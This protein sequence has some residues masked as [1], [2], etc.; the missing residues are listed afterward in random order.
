MDEQARQSFHQ[1]LRANPTTGGAGSHEDVVRHCSEALERDP[2]YWNAYLLLGSALIR[3]G[4]LDQAA[5]VYRDALTRHR[6]GEDDERVLASL[7]LE[8][9]SCLVASGEPAESIEILDAYALFSATIE[10]AT[11]RAESLIALGRTQDARRIIA[12]HELAGEGDVVGLLLVKAR[13]LLV[14]GG[15]GRAREV[16]VDVFRRDPTRP[17]LDELLPGVGLRL[18]RSGGMVRLVEVGSSP[19]SPPEFGM[20]PGPRSVPTP[21]LKFPPLPPPGR[22]IWLGAGLS[23][24]GMLLAMLLA[25]VVPDLIAGS[26]QTFLK[27]RIGMAIPWAV[28]FALAGLGGRIPEGRRAIAF[29]ALTG[30]AWLVGTVPTFIQ[31]LPGVELIRFATTF[32][33]AGAAGGLAWGDWRRAFRGALAGV[34]AG[35]LAGVLMYG[36]GIE[37]ALHHRM[38]SIT[39]DAFAAGLWGLMVW[40]GIA[41]G[42]RIAALRRR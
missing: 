11:V 9:A 13:A 20:G 22:V 5:D 1:A 2:R 39:A 17:G 6:R 24:V 27:W 21:E 4:L 29:G 12:E 8:L 42:E 23:L 30:V 28:C 38:P 7:V 40:L 31:G 26:S 18:E 34:V 32:A 41:L 10:G 25:S 19:A 15:H 14:E 37:R 36:V 3:L 35:I 33:W 16:L